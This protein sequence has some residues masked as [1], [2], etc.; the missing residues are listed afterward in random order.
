M[1]AKGSN[2][3]VY[4][5][6]EYE[7]QVFDSWGIEK[8][9]PS[10]IGAIYGAGPPRINAAKKPGEWQCYDILVERAAVKDGKIVKNAR[11]TVRHNNV[12]VQDQVEFANKTMAGT[13]GLQDHGNPVRYRNIWYVP[14]GVKP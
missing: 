13:L 8:P 14:L 12:L 3:G 6:G 1:V 11:L 7:V 10:D 2:S 4:V 5:Q 9:R